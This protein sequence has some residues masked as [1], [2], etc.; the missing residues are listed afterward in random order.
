MVLD[1]D[2]LN[3]E[4]K[5]NWEWFNDN[6][7]QNYIVDDLLI[8]L[9][10]FENEF[11]TDLGIPN[12][13]TEK[14][15]RMI[16]DEVNSNNTETALRAELWLERLK[17]CVTRVNGMFGTNITVEWRHD[18]NERDAI[19]SGN[20]GNAPGSHGQSENTGRA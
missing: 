5:L 4:G 15:E 2:L 8:D 10:K 17:E 16:T 20:T 14:R 13:N 11:C 6:L 3:D 9:R 18:P 19:N 7:G 1:S 12:S